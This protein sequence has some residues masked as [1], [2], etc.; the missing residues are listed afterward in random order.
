MFPE[1]DPDGDNKNS[2]AFV[3]HGAPGDLA[4]GV[5]VSYS[6]WNRRLIIEDIAVAPQYRG[7][8][9][10]RVLMGLAKEFACERGADHLWLEVTNINTPAIHAYRRMGFAFCGL[11]TTPTTTLPQEVSRRST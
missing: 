8:G 5:T 4:G 2:C 11:D 3:A 10:C 9:V 1:D 6:G 7:R